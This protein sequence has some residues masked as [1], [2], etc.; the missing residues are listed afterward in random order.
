MK[1]ITG[2]ICNKNAVDRSN[3]KAKYEVLTIHRYGW[4][5]EFVYRFHQD[6]GW[7]G[8]QPFGFEYPANAGL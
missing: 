8:D 1:I 2:C 7:A 4:I 5:L 3:Y 6:E